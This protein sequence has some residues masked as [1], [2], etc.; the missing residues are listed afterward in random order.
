MKPAKAAYPSD[1]SATEGEAISD[2]ALGL[3]DRLAG[4]PSLGNS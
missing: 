1:R 3:A 4:R 2:T